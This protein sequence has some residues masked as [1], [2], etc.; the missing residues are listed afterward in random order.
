VTE[1]PVYAFGEIT[2]DLRRM[3]VSRSG[4]AVTLEPKA[5][6]VLRYLIEHRERLVTKD[7]LLDAV[8]NGTFVTPNAL[9]RAV[10]QVRSSIGD[11][12]AHPTYIET[13][14]R[15]GYRFIAE[16]QTHTDEG[17][18]LAREPS[19]AGRPTSDPPAVVAPRHLASFAVVAVAVAIAVA[20]VALLRVHRPMSAGPVTAPVPERVTTRIGNSTSPSIASD[21]HAVAYVSDRTGGLEIYVV[22][23]VPGSREIPITA[24]GG[25][26]HQ[27]AWS[28]D[29]A[30]IAFH[31]QARGGIWIAP[32]TGGPAR[33]IVE[34]GSEPAWSP[35]GKR[36]VFT[37]GEGGM[38]TQA[39]LWIV[40]VDG[41]DR[42]PLT[43]LGVPPGG[44]HEPSWSRNGKLIAFAVWTADGARVWVVSTTGDRPPRQLSAELAHNPI[45]GPTDRMVFW[46]SWP[47]GFSRDE[48]R[49][50]PIDPDS[51]VAAGEPAPVIPL[52]GGRIDGL[53]MANDGTLAWGLE[54]SDINLWAVD[55]A[56]GGAPGQP[57]R[58]T[59]DVVR[60]AVPKYGPNGRIAYVR[61]DGEKSGTWI[62]N[63]DGSNREPLFAGSYSP[64]WN[65]DGSRVLVR[66]FGPSGAESLQWVDVDTRRATPTSLSALRPAEVGDLS[67]SRDSRDVAFHV[68]ESNG[69]MNV[70]T[71]HLD[72]TGERRLTSD[73]EAVSY[74]V[75]SPDGRS[76][77]VE[78]KRGEHTHIGVIARD[79]GPVERLTNESGQSWPFSW[80]PDGEWIAFAGERGGIWNVYEVSRR[81]KTTRALT[82]FSSSS[83]YVRYP[84]WS[85]HGNRIVFE[86]SIQTS[87]VWVARHRGR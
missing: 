84:S 13:V 1:L 10:A 36:L 60:N 27:P 52:S 73:T 11:A 75:W 21:G 74:P 8:W 87:N 19:T 59:D 68:I 46:A 18:G 81:T 40:N 64:Q 22:G 28:P 53:S 76:L 33:Q 5:F 2:V 34:T 29:G 83:G 23:L 9:T 45:F 86:R 70:W 56:P 67:L 72:G 66:T 16:V 71:R 6:D 77:A 24:D 62:M 79:G 30:W 48:V 69:A 54:T 4:A 43:T 39:T 63:E 15:R 32:S 25:E 55:V 7:E 12:V 14:P 42:R 80:S 57:V 49:G 20:A 17:P 44:H 61:L 85:P 58:L 38:K 78:I 37:S 35:D 47:G 51:G 82:H 26:N 50:V 31:S 41:S 65:S 3:T